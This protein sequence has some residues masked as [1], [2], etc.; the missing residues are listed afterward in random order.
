[1]KTPR[2]YTAFVLLETQDKKGHRVKREVLDK[3]YVRRVDTLGND[4]SIVNA[5]RVSYDKESEDF[6]DKDEKLLRFLLREKHFSPLRHAAITFEVYAPLMVARQWWKYVVS[7]SHTEDQLGWNESSRRYITED[8]EFYIPPAD[9]WRTKPDNSKQGSGLPIDP[10]RGTMWTQAL[11]QYVREG[12]RL[13][14]EALLQ[15]LAPEQARLFLPSYG[16]YVR[17]RWTASLQGIFH[18]LGERLEE[19]AQYEIREYAAA[20]SEIVTE[21]FPK[22]YAAWRT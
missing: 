14:T 2:V 18:F 12:E 22:T 5:A 15:G 16:M 19:H 4:L 20:V 1:M 11:E 17:W 21:T 7:S 8:E 9:S 6:T 10:E 13:Y 3:G